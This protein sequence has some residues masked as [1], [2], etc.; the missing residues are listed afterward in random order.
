MESTAEP[1]ALQSTAIGSG[2][3]SLPHLP[4]NVTA[5]G[6]SPT[7]GMAATERVLLFP[8]E[9]CTNPY[10]EIPEG[11][12]KSLGT[13]SFVSLES[14]PKGT[15]GSCWQ[16]CSA[17][18]PKTTGMDFSMWLGCTGETTVDTHV[19]AST[20]STGLKDSVTLKVLELSD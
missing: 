16:S 2:S 3:I 11:T 18:I 15:T 4:T 17:L 5:P 1:V 19:S 20:P 7:E 10:S 9:A 8:S 13:V 12:K 14:T 6:K